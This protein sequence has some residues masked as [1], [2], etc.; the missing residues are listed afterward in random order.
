[1]IW[2]WTYIYMYD[3]SLQASSPFRG[4]QEV[5]REQHAKGDGSVRGRVE[6]Q[7]EGWKIQLH[8]P[9][10][11]LTNHRRR[12]Q[13]CSSPQKGIIIIF[14]ISI[15]IVRQAFIAGQPGMSSIKINWRCIPVFQPIVFRFIWVKQKWKFTIDCCK[16]CFSLP[17]TACSHSLSDSLYSP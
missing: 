7:T 9:Q 3:P 15:S 17:L 13:F 2:I 1:M 16:L 8:S 10:K 5:M 6:I 4:V 14:L 11:L 12:G